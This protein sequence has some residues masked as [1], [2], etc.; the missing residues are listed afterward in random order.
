MTE[1]LAPEG[2]P[3]AEQAIRSACAKGVKLDIVGG[4]A[5]A[6]LGRPGA[7]DLRLSSAG[8]AGIVFYAPAEMTLCAKVGTTIDAIEAAIGARGQILPFE[9]M[10][11]QALWAASGKPTLGGMVATNL[12]GPRRPTAGAVRD[13]VLG[14]RLVNGLG[15]A[16]HCGGRVMKN[17]TGLDLTKLN[18]G[19]HGTLGFLTEATIKLAPRPQ[20]ETTLV[21]P[22]LDDASAIEAMTR[23]LGSPFGVSGAAWLQPGMGDAAART[24]LRLEGFRESVDD[25]ARRLAA[26]LRECEARQVGGEESSA[27][28]RS[29]RD[30]E[31]VAEP[32]ERAVWRVSLAPSQGPAFMVRLGA[33]ALAHAYDWG[34]G[35]VWVATDPTEAA[36]ANLRRAVEAAN[37]HATLMRASEDLRSRVAVFQPPSELE[38]R[39]ARGVK[40]SF[41]PGGVLNFGRMY[42]GV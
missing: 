39:L 15:Q 11:P 31:F 33:T 23:A 25:R 20:T 4:G 14:L 28:W 9:P 13:N 21:I 6:G 32:R 37:G 8:L 3:E 5:C 42:A 41:D 1:V 36:A 19:A 38:L 30:A 22:G 18:C 26:L 10:R 7:A 12:S 24:L 40:A 34:G 29:V 27:L 16:I 17:V 35:L 2:E